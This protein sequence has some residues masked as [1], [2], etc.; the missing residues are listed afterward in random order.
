MSDESRI[1]HEVR[2]LLSV[3]AGGPPVPAMHEGG[4]LSL[5]DAYAVQRRVFDELHGELPAA[6]KVSL[7]AQEHRDAFGA[8]EPTYGRLGASQLV[9]SG[10]AIAMT[11]LFHPLVEPELV[12]RVRRT[13][14]PGATADEVRASC[15]V[16]AGME[17]P[18]SRLRGWAPVPG[19]TVGDLVADGSFGGRIVHDDRGVA[20]EEVDLAVVTCEL[21][22]DGILLGS[23]RGDAV[24][25]NPVHAVAWLSG[26]LA[27]RGEVLVEG[28][29]ISS[30]TFFYP[31]TAEPGVYTASYSGVGEVSVT[32]TG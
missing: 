8:A 30:G 28:A 25:G 12:F 7:V 2:Q 19:Q 24:M 5:D 29:L 23:G 15:D 6:Y 16:R 27:R 26:A 14:S 3:H 1:A 17:I 9:G 32:F 13:L 21:R 31:P 22:R 18:D 10:G 11:D 4:E 20:A